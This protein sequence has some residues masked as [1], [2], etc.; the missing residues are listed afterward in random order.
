ME[1]HPSYLD[2][3]NKTDGASSDRA[4]RLSHFMNRGIQVRDRKG[5]YRDATDK[6]IAIMLSHVPTEDLYAFRRQCEGARSFSRFFH[7]A[8]KPRV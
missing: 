5:G 8:L 4:E 7:W 6:E 1:I 3:F 2:K